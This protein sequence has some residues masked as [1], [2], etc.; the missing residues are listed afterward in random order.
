VGKEQWQE[1]EKACSVLLDQQ[2][3]EVDKYIHAVI[4]EGKFKAHALW[5]K[6]DMERFDE[7]MEKCA[8]ALGERKPLMERFSSMT[9][10]TPVPIIT[11][12]PPDLSGLEE[13]LFE[14]VWPF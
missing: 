3:D 11:A 4:E 13:K 12:T 5:V 10:P 1:K 14:D 7:D 6:R 9:Y 2:D 8:D